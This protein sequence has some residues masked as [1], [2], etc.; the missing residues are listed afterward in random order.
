MNFFFMFQDFSK[1]F[2]YYYL[3]FGVITWNGEMIGMIREMMNF[4]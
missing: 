4:F 3:L 1:L 2:I